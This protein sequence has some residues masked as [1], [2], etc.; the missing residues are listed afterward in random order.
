[1]IFIVQNDTIL[2]HSVC[3]FAPR[4]DTSE[5]SKATDSNTGTAIN[6]ALVIFHFG[7]MF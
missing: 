4:T 1:M 2:T 6:S 3:L 5:I 7:G